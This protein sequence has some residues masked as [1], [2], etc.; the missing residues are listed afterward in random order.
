MRRTQPD[1]SS[2]L[3]TVLLLPCLERDAFRETEGGRAARWLRVETRPAAAIL[4]CLRAL[5]RPTFT[6]F[7]SPHAGR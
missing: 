5:A 1:F 4:V 2:V 3:P 6:P 7:A